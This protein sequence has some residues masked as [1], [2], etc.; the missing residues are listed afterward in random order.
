MSD[1]FLKSGPDPQNG[2]P[3]KINPDKVENLSSRKSDRQHT[4]FHQQSTTNSPSKNHV[5]HPVFAKSPSKDDHS[6]APEKLLQKRSL[7]GLGFGFFGGDDDGGGYFVLVFEVEQLDALGAAAGGADGFGVDADDLAE[8]ADD[9][10]LAGVVH[11]IDTGHFTDLRRRLHVDDALAAAGLEAVL[12]DVG[13]F[14]VA[15]LGDREDEAGGEAELLVE[16]FEFRCCCGIDLFVAAE[17]LLAVGSV[18]S[19]GDVAKGWRSRSLHFAA[20]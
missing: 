18:D 19:G 3:V 13:A 16:F 12:V 2:N 6:P 9:H 17:N 20:G 5:L 10:Q 14:A 4:T 1:P 15:V 11:K 8:L 7:F